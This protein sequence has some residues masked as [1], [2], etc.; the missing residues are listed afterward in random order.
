MSASPKRIISVTKDKV[1]VIEIVDPLGKKFGKSF[2]FAWDE[3]TLDSVFS[4]AVKK[5]SSRD[6]RILV[7]DDLSYTLRTALPVE[8]SDQKVRE[9]VLGKLREKI[10]E[11]VEEGAWDFR[12]IKNAAGQSRDAIA[13]ALD[14]NFAKALF[15]AI[16]RAGINVEAM[17][18]EIIA[19]TRD[20]NAYVGIALK[21]D[22]TG[23]DKDV[24]NIR[25][26]VVIK[27]DANAP[28]SNASSEMASRKLGI[29]LF[30]IL[31]PIVLVGI[32]FGGFIYLQKNVPP[33]VDVND[34][35]LLLT[36]T[37]TPSPESA[38][39][40]ETEVD[41]K[42]LKV[43]VRNGSGMPGEATR[44]SD[45]LKNS[46][47]EIIETKN[48]DSFDFKETEVR[49]KEK[50]APEVLEIIAKALSGD[51]EVIQSDFLDKEARFDI[52][53]VVGQKK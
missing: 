24:L 1:I 37:P 31:I 11:G 9:Y 22:L 2:E 21:E 30:I 29:K 12:E 20:A 53:I 47:F 13:F 51:Y 41:L 18:P 38:A 23:Q 14:K 19:K 52:V 17:E 3:T 28:V 10:P 48:A 16:A 32:L 44:V 33:L 15:G 39:Q 6:F 8:I 45:I 46:G 40:K 27:E 7:S 35:G 42:S 4:E 49:L 25:P 36:P 50:Y 34:G 43:E 5:F 26:M